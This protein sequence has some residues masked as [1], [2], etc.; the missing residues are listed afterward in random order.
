M[1]YLSRRKAVIRNGK[2]ENLAKPKAQDFF[3]KQRF[4]KSASP[5]DA[6]RKLKVHKT[7]RRCPGRRVSAVSVLLNFFMN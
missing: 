7:F 5:I 2:T 6:G 3:Y 1:T 4:F